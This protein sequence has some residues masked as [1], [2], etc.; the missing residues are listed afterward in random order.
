MKYLAFFPNWIP[1]MALIPPAHHLHFMSGITAYA[2]QG[3][4]FEPVHQSE[5]AV[6][7]SIRPTI[8]ASVER[9]NQKIEV[10][11]RNARLG[12]LAKARIMRAERAAAD[13]PVD[14]A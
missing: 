1:L 5:E 6:F 13:Y 3:R 4:P 14:E 10:Q 2:T 9:Y 7:A 12:G 8:D 11:R